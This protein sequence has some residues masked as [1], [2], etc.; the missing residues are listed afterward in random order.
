MAGTRD[1]E[2]AVMSR[3]HAIVGALALAAGT[4]IASTPDVAL[5]TNGEPITAGHSFFAS[6]ENA[7]RL[8]S[9]GT[10]AGDELSYA[11]I[12]RGGTTGVAIRSFG[13]TV[14]SAAP[15]GSSGV[16]GE[17]WYAQHLGVMA[18][19]H[20]PWGTALRVEGRA[21]F[22]RSGKAAIGKKHSTAVVTVA[23]GIDTN[24]LILVTLQGSGGSGVYLK[25][26]KRMTATTFKVA[27]NKKATSAVAFAWMI[28]D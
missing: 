3:R 10:I 11:V 24:S 8:T 7:F 18:V 19:N 20:S 15:V 21:S 27:L 13:G 16:L 4:L 26:A 1:D 12:N 5:A 22:Q 9:D 23:S 2:S 17:A 25:Y 28:V 14:F 6:A